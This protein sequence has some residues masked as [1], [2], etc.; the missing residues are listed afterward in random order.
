MRLY[1]ALRWIKTGELREISG[2][3][4]YLGDPRDHIVIQTDTGIPHAHA[5]NSCSD[6]DQFEWPLIDDLPAG[7]GHD[8]R[9][10][11]KD[12]KISIRG[13]RVRFG[14]KD[15]A[16][17]ERALERFGVD[18]LAEHMRPIGDEVDP[19]G[20]KSVANWTPIWRK[21][22]PAAC[23][24]ST[25]LPGLISAA[26]RWYPGSVISSQNRRTMSVGGPRQMGEPTC[27]V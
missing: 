25:G 9:M 12:P 16:G 10:T 27:A 22:L 1:G 23:T 14:H 15:H 17:L 19:M 6:H 18:V 21:N 20:V 2:L 11:K 8:V 24:A 4:A 5:Q 13:N 7:L 26:M 3:S